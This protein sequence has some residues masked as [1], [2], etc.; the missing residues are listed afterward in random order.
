MDPQ[1]FAHSKS[2]AIPFLSVMRKKYDWEELQK[3]YN[4]GL[5]LRDLTAKYGIHVGAL[6]KARDRGDLVF[7]TRTQASA[8]ALKTKPRRK[9]T[10]ETKQKIS[11]IR[12]A[13]LAANPD[14]V[15]YRLNHYSKGPSYPERY[16]KD[17]F[18]KEQIAVT[19]EHQLSIY[20]L[21][22]AD[23]ARKIDIEIDGEQHF[24]DERIAESDKRRN[25][26]LKER[27]WTVFRIRWSE[28]KKMAYEQKR[29]V[30]SDLKELIAK[31]PAVNEF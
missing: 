19:T 20:Q 23:V 5:S 14:K 29:A 3:A 13:Y 21:D 16:F 27:G 7:R 11:M 2:G 18:E 28:Y 15:P 22:F 10:E 24:A 6:Y 25:Q 4:D 8:L 12:R 9:H 26:F 17:L 1:R 30:V 31:T